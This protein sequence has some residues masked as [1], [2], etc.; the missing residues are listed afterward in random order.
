MAQL[1]LFPLRTLT[2][3]GD[4]FTHLSRYGAVSEERAV[5]YIAEILLALDCLHQHGVVYR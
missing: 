5:L 2:P 1:C 3:A 4:L